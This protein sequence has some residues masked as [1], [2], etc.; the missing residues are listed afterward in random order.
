[1]HRIAI[2]TAKAGTIRYAL[3]PVLHDIASISDTIALL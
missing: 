2:I 1:M 3:S